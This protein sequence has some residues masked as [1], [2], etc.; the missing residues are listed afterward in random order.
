LHW[1]NAHVLTLQLPFCFEVG[2]L[3]DRL[4]GSVPE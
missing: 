1:P 4:V 3:S 2:L